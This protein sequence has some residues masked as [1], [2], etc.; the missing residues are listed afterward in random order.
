MRIDNRTSDVLLDDWLIKF[1]GYSLDFQD[2]LGYYSSN[3]VCFPDIYSTSYPALPLS[4]TILFNNLCALVF[5]IYSYLVIIR[6]TFKSKN[7]FTYRS[8]SNKS[9]DN[10][11]KRVA[12]III[13]DALC[14]APII[15]TAFVGYCGKDLPLLIHPLSAIVVLPINSVINPMIYSKIDDLVWKVFQ[16]LFKR[17]RCCSRKREAKGSIVEMDNL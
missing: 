17:I 9:N 11:K 13:T 4:F 6:K 15:I 3:S 2:Y 1:P 16:S 8:S 5:I 14:W 7:T 12:Y 10:L